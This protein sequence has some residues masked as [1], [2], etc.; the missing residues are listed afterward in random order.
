VLVVVGVPV[1]VRVVAVLVVC[2]AVVTV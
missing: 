2:V 1:A